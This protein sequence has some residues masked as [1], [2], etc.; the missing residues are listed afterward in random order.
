[1]TEEL[2]QQEFDAVVE[3]LFITCHAMVIGVHYNNLNL[4]EV[5]HKSLSVRVD[6]KFKQ[7]IAHTI[8]T[9]DEKILFEEIPKI[10][11]RQ[12]LRSLAEFF[13]LVLSMMFSAY[14][15]F[16]IAPSYFETTKTAFVRILQWYGAIT[17]VGHAIDIY[18]LNRW[19][20]AWKHLERLH[21]DS[22]FTPSRHA[23]YLLWLLLPQQSR[24]AMLG[25]LSE[26]FE[27]VATRH[28]LRRAK[29]W[30]WCQAL[31]SAGPLLG[32]FLGLLLRLPF[33]R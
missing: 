12:N 5:F 31:R 32:R 26:G 20:R 19:R 23:E 14:A 22:Y 28:G 13:I 30:Y 6:T 9:I 2:K 29:F 18:W 25:D 16:I 33:L 15:I 3:N 10:L 11:K 7:N 17:L 27:K 4:F 21:D 1:M 8:S 24:D